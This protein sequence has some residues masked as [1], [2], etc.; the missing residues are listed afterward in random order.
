[1]KELLLAFAAGVVLHMVYKY[2]RADQKNPLTWFKVE[3]KDILGGLVADVLMG[4]AY[5]SGYGTQLLGGAFG[6]M[7]WTGEIPVDPGMAFMVGYVA[8][9]VGAGILSAAAGKKS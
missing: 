4:A 2:V 1:M 7:G 9:S 8:D 3:R 6:A 5:V